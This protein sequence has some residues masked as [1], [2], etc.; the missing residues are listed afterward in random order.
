MVGKN[1]IP[2]IEAAYFEGTGGQN[3]PVPV[4]DYGETWCMEIPFI[5]LFED[6]MYRLDRIV[7]IRG[8]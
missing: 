3:C 4:F 1:I 2:A 5:V 6:S 8:G 7:V